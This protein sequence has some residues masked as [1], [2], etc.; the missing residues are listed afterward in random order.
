MIRL[1]RPS[2]YFQKAAGV[3]DVSSLALGPVRLDEP[4][5]MHVIELA[6]PGGDGVHEVYARPIALRRKRL[7]F[8]FVANGRHKHFGA[9]RCVIVPA[10]RIRQAIEQTEYGCTRP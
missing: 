4:H 1:L 6:E 8:H 9:S 5:E 3:E 10:V 2:K 7:A